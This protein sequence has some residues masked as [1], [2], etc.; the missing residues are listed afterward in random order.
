M[1]VK[2]YLCQRTR[3]ISAALPQRFDQRGIF[4]LIRASAPQELTLDD[5]SRLLP[6]N[7]H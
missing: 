5:D 4:S 7:I 2:P 3:A 1:V 6:R